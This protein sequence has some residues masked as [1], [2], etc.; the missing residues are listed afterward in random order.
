MNDLQERLRRFADEGARQARSPGVEAALRR[1]RHRRRRQLGAAAL[2]LAALLAGGLGIRGQRTPLP[3]HPVA[4]GPTVTGAGP[5]VTGVGRAPV[6]LPREFEPIPG[7]VIA[8][9]DQPGYRW[10]L[11]ARRTRLLQGQ[12]EV[13]MVFQHDDYGPGAD[14]GT[15]EPVTLSLLTPSTRDPDPVVAGVVTRRAARVRLWLRRDGAQFPPVDAP[16]IDGGRDFPESF[17]VAF[18]PKGSLLRDVVLLDR[19]GRQICHQRFTERSGEDQY[20]VP[21]AGACF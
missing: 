6:S 3:V 1:G 5:T 19:A 16:V 10:R 13:T 11:V 21:D 17:F 15:L 4:P 20:P 8:H 2:A 7:R 14:L 9:G 12:R 18:V